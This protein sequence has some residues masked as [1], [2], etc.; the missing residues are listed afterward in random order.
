MDKKITKL[1]DLKGLYIRV[2]QSAFMMDLVS[3]LGANPVEMPYEMVGSQLRE[4]IIDGAENNIPSFVS[5]RHS[6][7]APYLVPFEDQKIIR[8]AALESSVYQ[9]ELWKK[10]EE[11]NYQAFQE[12]GGTITELEDLSEFVKKVQPIYDQYVPRYG[13]VIERIRAVGLTD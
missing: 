6:S 8:Q 2:Q 10:E 5:A 7:L 13:N 3:M 1:S 12:A 9:R 4:H 11:K